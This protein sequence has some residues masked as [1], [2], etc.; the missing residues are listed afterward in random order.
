MRRRQ[1]VSVGGSTRQ[2]PAEM[3]Q[4]SGWMWI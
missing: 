2:N 3:K 1:A 4:F